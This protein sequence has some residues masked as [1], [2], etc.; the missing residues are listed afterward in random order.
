MGVVCGVIHFEDQTFGYNFIKNYCQSK[1]IDL[2][3]DYPEDKLISIMTIDTLVVKNEKG[4]EIVGVG[5]QIIGADSEG[6]EVF[7]LGVPYPFFEEEFPHHVKAYK[8][9]FKE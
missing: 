6:Y 4:I 9:M 1:N 7:L 5:S 2:A 8:E 3:I